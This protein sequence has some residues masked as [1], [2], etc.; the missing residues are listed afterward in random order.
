M[1][2][3]QTHPKKGS[4]TPAPEPDEKQAPDQPVIDHKSEV[5]EHASKESTDA[6]NREDREASDALM[7]SYN[8]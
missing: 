8:G 3:R 1:T 6:S 2:K 4:E 5:E 7:E